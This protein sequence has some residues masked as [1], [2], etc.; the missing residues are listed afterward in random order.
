MAL[1]LTRTAAAAAAALLVLVGGG[2]I[3]ARQIR[4]PAQV[5]ADT[6]APT[7]SPITA[8]VTR[9]TL[10]T[11]VIVR[12]TVR[13]GAPQAVVLA[14]SKLKQ[15]SN[16]VTRAPRRGVD[17]AAG[18]LAMTVDGRPVFVL[19]GSVP[20]HRDLGPGSRGTDVG[21][22]EVAL[23]GMGFSPGRVDG[24]YDQ[25]TQG[26]VTRFYLDRGYD[27]FGATDLQLD[28]L[29]TAEAA[30]AQAN[31][32]H[33]QARSALERAQRGRSAAEVDRA[34]GEALTASEAVAGASLRVATAAQ[35]L[36]TA[37]LTASRGGT[38]TR[39]AERDATAADAEVAAKSAELGAARDEVEL[40]I[41]RRLELPREATASERDGATL[42]VRQAQDAVVRARAAL[43]AA[44]AAARS[45]R[46]TG[47]SAVQRAQSDAR[48]AAA[49]LRRARSGVTLAKRQARLARR[50]VALLARRPDVP[51]TLGEIS[52]AT[53][54]EAR[55][56]RAEVARLSASAGI[57]VPADEVLFF[58]T[59]PLR[60]DAVPATRGSTVA[61]R[62]MNVTNSRLAVDSSLSASDAK[63]VRPG[64]PVLVEEQDLG[65]RVRGRVSR[66][67]ATPGTNRVDPSRFAFSVVPEG[68]AASLVGASV[69]LTIAVRST[70]GEVLAVPVG[71]LSVGGDGSS[72]VRVR[73][74][75]RTELVTVVPGLAAKGLVEVRPV[76]PELLSPGDLVVVGSGSGSGTTR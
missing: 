31:D 49:E 67:A 21:Q 51:A 71:G 39:D 38:A 20:M 16:I 2:W 44:R 47:A 34:R 28:Q 52:R 42:A 25:A 72:R 69:K 13:F 17:L 75:P 64:D 66:V 46:A 53:E 54:R 3:A 73:R 68:G 37:R 41:K 40:S 36:A 65:I 74:G 58:P 4:S 24:R 59:L 50:R 60:V 61:G 22:L 70:E 57:Q 1:G 18:D 14:T 12:G 19:P 56:T 48:I 15:G 55:R 43:S 62:V 35:K 45:A 6:A 7:P 27:P 8:P 10:S 23:A 33:L 29:N 9:R 26:A 11:D 30:A 63:L 32:A 76:G 5:A